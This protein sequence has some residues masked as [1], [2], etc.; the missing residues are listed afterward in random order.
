MLQSSDGR[1]NLNDEFLAAIGTQHSLDEL[2]G[3]FGAPLESVAGRRTLA[4]WLALIWLEKNAF[5][6]GDHWRQAARKGL[7]WLKTSGSPALSDKAW[8]Q[9]AIEVLA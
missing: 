9:V 7:G 8:N 2:I 4:T 3:R 1:W 6:E 5:N